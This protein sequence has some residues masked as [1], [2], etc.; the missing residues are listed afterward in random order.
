VTGAFNPTGK[1]P[2]TTPVNQAAVEA[3]KSDVPGHMEG[4]GYGLFAFG[5][6]LSY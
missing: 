6:G 5:Q 2:F 3:N 1:M 4:P